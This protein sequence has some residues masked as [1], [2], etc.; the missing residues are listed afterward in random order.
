MESCF[1]LQWS[2]AKGLL[3][4]ELWRTLFF[5]TTSLLDSSTTATILLLQYQWTW[6]LQQLPSCDY[7]PYASLNASFS[8][9]TSTHVYSREKIPLE[10]LFCAFKE[11][12]FFPTSNQDSKYPPP[13]RHWSSNGFTN[14]DRRC[15]NVLREKKKLYST[16]IAANEGFCN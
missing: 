8:S 2:K 7:F 12:V 11:E 15:S 4:K 1:F 16:T 9:S 3:E 13:R 14:D 6:V 10:K 5:K